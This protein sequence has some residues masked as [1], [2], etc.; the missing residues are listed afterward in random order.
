MRGGPQGTGRPGRPPHR[1][2]AL[3]ART[4]ARLATGL[5]LGT[6]AALLIAM[7]WAADP[8]PVRP[9]PRADLIRV[10]VVEG[11]SVPG[12][13]DSSRGELDSLMHAPA[14]PPTWALVTLSAYYAPD[15]LP[16]VLAGSA[17]AQVYARPPLPDAGTEVVR[18]PAYRLPDDVV[19][20]M[21][22]AAARRD[23]EQADYR[24]LSRR[25][26]GGDPH[27]ARLRQAY[28]SAASVAAAEAGAYRRRCACVFAAVVRAAP[29][30]LHRIANRPEVRAVDPAPEVNALDRAEFSPPLPEQRGTIP[31]VTRSATI[32]AQP[33]TS[34]VAP[35][36]PTPLPSSSGPPVTSASSIDP[37][38]GS[39]PSVPASEDRSAV[40]SAP[41]PTP[42]PG[43]PAGSPAASRRASGR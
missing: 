23:R 12:Y 13:V 1:P 22:A 5:A 29:A 28:E 43:V 32:P 24:R 38:A 37:A 6:V 9:S 14:G 18:I 11:Q 16:A 34:T 33:G 26:D 8:D 31:E 3:N 19:A 42:D 4:G 35:V 27:A 15:R 2:R 7:L 41:P 39:G 17:V 25:L 40:P 21:L 30:A 10:G 20:G 36:R